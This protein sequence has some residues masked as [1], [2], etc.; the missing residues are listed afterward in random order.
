MQL[1]TTASGV[2]S[3]VFAAERDFQLASLDNRGLDVTGT[4][5]RNPIAQPPSAIRQRN[6]PRSTA[7]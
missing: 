2:R 4:V 5:T 6:S 3:D 7:P 1:A